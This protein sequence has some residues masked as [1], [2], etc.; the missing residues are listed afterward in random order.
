M[1]MNPS[2][3]TLSI[4]SSHSQSISDLGFGQCLLQELSISVTILLKAPEVR[5]PLQNNLSRDGQ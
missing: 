5:S 3:E 1:S 4:L 2:N